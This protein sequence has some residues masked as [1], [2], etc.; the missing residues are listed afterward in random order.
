MAK[1]GQSPARAREQHVLNPL[2]NALQSVF[3]KPQKKKH[4]PSASGSPVR[5]TVV[6]KKHIHF[7]SIEPRVLLSADVNPTA[8]TIGGSID[9]PGE[10]DSYEFTVEETTRI[11][12][13]SQTANYNLKWRLDGPVGQISN[14]DFL[15]DDPAIELAAGKYLLTVDGSGDQTGAYNLRLIDAATA[16]DLAPGEAVSGTLDGGNKTAVY[17]FSA[18]AGDKFFYDGISLSG[19]NAYWRLIDPFGRQEQGSNW[20][21]NDYDTFAVQRTGTYLV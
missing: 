4:P 16:A 5:A 13:D 8:L 17:Q 12:F 3:K 7:E 18:T 6:S 10:Q 1:I 9:V 14:Q 21:S 2:F 20:L 19:G 15:Y 11:A